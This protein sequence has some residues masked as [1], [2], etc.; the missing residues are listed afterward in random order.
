[1]KNAKYNDLREKW[2]PIVYL[3]ISQTQ[4]PD[5]FQQVMIH[6]AMPLADLT[7]TLRRAIDGINPGIN[8][9]CQAF[10]TQIQESLLPERLMAALSGFFGLLAALLTAVGLYGVISFLVARRT[11]EIGTR[12]ALG[13]GKRHVLASILRET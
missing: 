7:S 11:H 1:V 13:A 5:S 4:N 10:K 2:Q 3:P 12:M 6:S 9:D 8:V